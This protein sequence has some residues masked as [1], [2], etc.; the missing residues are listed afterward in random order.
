MIPFVP[1]HI[2]LCGI[3]MCYI[4]KRLICSVG[5]RSSRDEDEE[6]LC[7]LGLCEITAR[8]RAQCLSLKSGVRMKGE[9]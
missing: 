4:Y 9:E 1:F 3:F 6:I 5:Q 8:M 7:A 2:V